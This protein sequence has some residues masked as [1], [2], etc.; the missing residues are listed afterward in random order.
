VERVAEV[1]VEIPEELEAGIRELGKEELNQIV[2]EALREKLSE[3]LMF[4]LADEL[5][6]ESRLTED[7]ALELARELRKLVAEK[8]GL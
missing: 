4:K 5:L 2:R 8:H 7:V 3:R 1:T 6:K